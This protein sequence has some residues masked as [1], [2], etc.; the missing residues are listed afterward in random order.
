M[1][2]YPE[3]NELGDT[4]MISRVN[5]LPSKSEIL[6]DESITREDLAEMLL[7]YRDELIPQMTREYD[8][9]LESVNGVI[10]DTKDMQD[11]MYIINQTV[12]GM[13]VTEECLRETIRTLKLRVFDLEHPDLK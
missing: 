9:I 12:N 8:N 5:S 10:N 2:E 6:N 1:F 11:S 13:T 7:H 4:V 3:P